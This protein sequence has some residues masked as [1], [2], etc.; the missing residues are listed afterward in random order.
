MA[1]G[2][3]DSGNEGSGWYWLLLIPV[4]GSL[5][6][7]FYNSAEPSWGGFPFFY[8]FQLVWVVVSAVITAAVYFLTTER[9]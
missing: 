1:N 4:I 9:K 6:V 7:P 2:P 3:N 5:W 8:W